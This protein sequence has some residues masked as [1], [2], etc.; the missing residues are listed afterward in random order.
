MS[1]NCMTKASQE[2]FCG[3]KN[4]NARWYDPNLGRFISEDPARAGNNWFEYCG[5]NPLTSTDPY[6]LWT[7]SIGIG[8]EAGDIVSF[9]I[10]GGQFSFSSIVGA[11]GGIGYGSFNANDSG[12]S[13][14]GMRVGVGY[15]G[16]SSITIP[17]GLFSINS[18]VKGSVTISPGGKGFESENVFSG[19]VT[20]TK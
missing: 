9:G 12:V 1:A 15:E 4:F 19:S 11:V 2:R 18:S 7:F 10:N 3:W 6:G 14:P 17:E 8:W 16:R 13:T 5:D 20:A